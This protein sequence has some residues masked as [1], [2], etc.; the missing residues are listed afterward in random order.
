MSDSS[1]VKSVHI[2][3]E[4][5]GRHVTVKAGST[6]LDA[7]RK[8]GIELIS[9]CG[10]AGTCK[11]C[12]IQLVEGELSPPGLTETELFNRKEIESGYR[13]ACQAVPLSNV[14]IYIPQESLTTPQR[15]Q[16]EGQE[17]GVALDPIVKTID[18]LLKPPDL[19]DLRADVT[20]LN[21]EIH[22]H[23]IAPARIQLPVLASLSDS[24]RAQDWSVRL[25][26]RRDEIVAVLQPGKSPMGLAVDVGTTKLAAYLVDLSTGQSVAKAGAMNPQIA[27]GE[28]VVSRISYAVENEGGRE[29]L[30]ATLI[31]GIDNLITNLCDEANVIR[32]QVVEVVAVGNTAMHHLFAG[33]PV[34]QLGLA[35]YVP[36]VSEPLEFPAAQIGL[37]LAPG[38]Y[39]HLP[40]NIAGYVG[41]DHVAMLLASDIHESRG[42][43]VA[44]DIGTNTEITLASNGQMLSCSCASGPAFEGA[45]LQDG[46]RAAP[47]A[48]ERVQIEKGE[49]RIQTIAGRPPVGICGS[50]IL[51]A[52]SEMSKEGVIDK[53]GRFQKDSP[54]VRTKDG[55]EEFVLAPSSING[56]QRDI[57]IT[58]KD[59]NEIQ[60]AKG[61]IRAGINILLM[62]AGIKPDDIDE[63]VV[64]GAFGTYIDIESAIQ[65]GMF[66]PIP[67][68]RFRQVGNAAG[69]GAKQMLISAARRK[70]AELI[71][72]RVKYIELTTH[73]GFTEEFLEAMYF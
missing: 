34:R 53:G 32:N 59:V 41:A 57:V 31:D 27:Y 68:G 14:K 30:R 46:M 25:A 16:I 70:Q 35:P 22:K 45:H 24:L 49:I 40:S 23:G 42:N 36:A 39:V 62:E 8:A 18:V 1:S 21:D 52:I 44:V 2:H 61:A 3:I 47:G 60:L 20:R 54:L 67:A 33:L 28:D 56:H 5:I 37:D 58:R 50:G 55:K 29:R 51:D 15:L 9:P 48:I 73:K 12:L 69:I 19:N 6:L 26:L 11:S 4:P 17:I 10:G 13:L 72:R 65:V 7:S 64:A 43:T 71:A 63:F 66:P 38:A